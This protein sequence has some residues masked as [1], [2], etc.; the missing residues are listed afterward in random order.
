MKKQLAAFIALAILLI[1]LSSCR[2]AEQESFEPEEEKHSS[3]SSAYTVEPKGEDETAVS[4]TDTSKTSGVFD[5]ESRTVLLNSGYEMP[6]LGLGT[7][8]LDHDI[9]TNRNL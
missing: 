7:Y 8:A 5:F 2:T 4:Q 9:P 3:N 6:I 1:C